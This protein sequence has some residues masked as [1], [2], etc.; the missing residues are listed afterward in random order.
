MGIPYGGYLRGSVGILFI[1]IEKGF[2]ERFFCACPEL[3]LGDINKRFPSFRDN[4][5]A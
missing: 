5:I 3:N 1:F 4:R 2:S